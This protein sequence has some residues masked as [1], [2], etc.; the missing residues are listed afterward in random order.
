VR[1]QPNCAPVPD[2]PFLG[3]ITLPLTQIILWTSLRTK[4]VGA[5]PLLGYARVSTSEQDMAAQLD[6]LA[7]ARCV[8]VFQ[9]AAS[10][11]KADRPGLTAALSY[12]RDGDILVVW[13]LDRLGRS[14]SSASSY[15]DGDQSGQASTCAWS[16][17]GAA[18]HL[19][20]TTSLRIFLATVARPMPQFGLLVII[21][22]IPA[23]ACA[24]RET[25][26]R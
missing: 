6:A 1:R 5:M 25:E 19:F 4:A 13:K 24:A 7:A 15:R 21:V 2:A 18:M 26:L 20:A 12:V 22:I 17:A 10:G 3:R 23:P 11:A 14:A 16:L 9:D 8:Q